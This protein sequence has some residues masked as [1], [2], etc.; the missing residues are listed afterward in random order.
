[1]MNERIRKRRN[2]LGLTQ[3]DVARLLGTSKTAISLWESGTNRPNGENLHLLAKILQCTSEYLLHGDNEGLK[4]DS[5]REHVS[6]YGAGDLGTFDLWD[7]KTPLNDDEVELPFFKEVA[8]SAGNGSEVVKE[9]TGLKLRFA[10]STLKRAGV[11]PETAAC[12]SVVGNSMEP[13]LPDKAVVG[14][15]TSQTR[16]IDGK[17][18]AINHDGMLRVKLLYRIPG[19]GIRLKSYN[20]EEYPDEDVHNPVES[21]LVILGRVF[22]SSVMW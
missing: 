15:D 22:W 21:K 1:M 7:S 8:L 12:V 16:V 19:G 3:P 2:E 6:N 9:S 17:M 4:T 11:M 14:V 13:V 18:Y 20:K 5:I 10:K